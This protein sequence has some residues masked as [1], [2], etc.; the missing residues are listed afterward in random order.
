MKQL[1]LIMIICLLASVLMACQTIS[2]EGTWKD[3]SGLSEL[4]FEGDEVN[5]FGTIGTFVI[6]KD[7]L[8]MTLNDQVIEFTFDLNE[9]E[10]TLYLNEGKIVLE[11]Q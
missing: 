6:E 10:L 3:P 5:F 8:M 9:N 2:I 7:Q 11:R 1:R 4:T